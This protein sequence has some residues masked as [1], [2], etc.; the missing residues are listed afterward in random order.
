MKENNDL[1]YFIWFLDKSSIFLNGNGSLTYCSSS[2]IFKL[3]QQQNMETQEPKVPSTVY[4]KPFQRSSCSFQCRWKYSLLIIIAN[5]NRNSVQH[6]LDNL[7]GQQQISLRPW[8]HKWELI[9]E[10][11]PNRSR[12]ELHFQYRI[13]P[14][15]QSTKSMQTLAQRQPNL[16]H[17]CDQKVLLPQNSG[18]LA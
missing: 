2:S 12:N 15:S 10:S 6:R 1:Y 16:Q 4:L 7:Y 3:C 11:N 9:S 14:E 18:R 5:F 17:Q 13:T 8:F